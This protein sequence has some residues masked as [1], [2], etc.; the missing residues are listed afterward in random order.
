MI[1]LKKLLLLVAEKISG[2]MGHNFLRALMLNLKNAL[3]ADLVLVTEGI[4]EPAGR[5]RSIFCVQDS[6][7]AEQIEYD[8]AATPCELVYQGKHV[9]IPCDLAKRF[10][11]EEGYESYIGSPLRDRA[12]KVIGHFSVFS[13][14]PLEQEEDS[15]RLFR[16]FASRVEMELQREAYERERESFI[17]TLRQ[18]N[19]LLERQREIARKS[20]SVKSELLRIVAH[21]MRSPLGTVI[22]RNELAQTFIQ[23]G[24]E[25]SLKTA[26][27]CCEISI[28][29]VER[30]D[31]LIQDLLQSAK[32]DVTEMSFA[33]NAFDL[34]KTLSAIIRL[35]EA[36]ALAKDISIRGSLPESLMIVAD[37]NR[38]T[39]AVD[40]LMNNAVK[41]SPPGKSISLSAET[42]PQGGV[43]ICVKD[44]GQGFMHAEIDHVFTRF[45]ALSA[46][47]TGGEQSTGLG[48]SIVKAIAERHGGTVAVKSAGQGKG[49]A[50]ILNLPSR[51]TA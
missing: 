20:N 25:T 23:R 47:P 32:D 39:E 1:D 26:F 31:A 22:S 13:R 2:E 19:A 28:E 4:G 24:D 49:A 18:A 30:M 27:T 40:N 11:K 43:K 9:V 51:A 35:N 14:A 17:G 48:L 50:F 44:Q 34:T 7:E 46:K 10:P 37:E 41:F 38:L 12:K 15:A 21:D 5:A 16:I 45:A 29:A 33:P 42:T 6:K 3:N 8:L 36:A